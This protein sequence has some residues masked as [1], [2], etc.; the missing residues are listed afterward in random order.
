MTRHELIARLRELRAEATGLDEETALAFD[1]FVRVMEA[2][3]EVAHSTRVVEEIERRALAEQAA[4]TD[5]A[6]TDGDRDPS[7]DVVE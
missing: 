1:L 6:R 5:P 2:G 3:T 4:A 7:P